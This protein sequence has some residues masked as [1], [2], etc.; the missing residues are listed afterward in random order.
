[1]QL[2]TQTVKNSIVFP[3][4]LIGFVTTAL[5]TIGCTSDDT[6]SVANPDPSVLF[7]QYVDAVNAHDLETLASLTAPDAK[8]GSLVGRDALLRQNEFDIE[9]GIRLETRDVSVQGN[10]V[11]ATLI[12]RTDFT[13]AHGPESTIHYVR[14]VFQNGMVVS[15]SRTRPDPQTDEFMSRTI[16]FRQWVRQTHPEAVEKLTS[17]PRVLIITKES[18]VLT[19]EL[20]AEWVSLGRPGLQR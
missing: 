17:A 12:E 20:L 9:T 5:M 19:A 15:K 13:R 4:A 8:W 16:P 6:D 2:M 1:M 7:D 14:F 10:A 3:V 11:E 18:G